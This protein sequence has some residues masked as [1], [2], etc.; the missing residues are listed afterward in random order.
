M[1]ITIWADAI[2][3]KLTLNQA[4]QIKD[5]VI[6]CTCRSAA[7]GIWLVVV[8]AWQQRHWGILRMPEPLSA[9]QT[10]FIGGLILPIVAIDDL[11]RDKKGGANYADLLLGKQSVSFVVFSVQVW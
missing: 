8:A 3:D 9:A 2:I 7:R 5:K 11:W 6:L 10:K 4:K 1:S